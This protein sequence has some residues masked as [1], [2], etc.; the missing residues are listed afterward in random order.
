MPRG[1]VGGSRAAAPSSRGWT[2]AARPAPVE[3]IVELTRALIRVPSR[4]G[5][6]PYSPVFG[7]LRAWLRARAV[8]FKILGGKRGGPVCLLVHRAPSSTSPVYLLNATVD[9][10]PFGNEE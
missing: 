2:A 4:A 9:T 3:S 7:V 8:P 1:K 10:A 6:D 5:I